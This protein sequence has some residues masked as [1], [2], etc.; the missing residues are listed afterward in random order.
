MW[1]ACAKC[2]LVLG[3]GDGPS[4]LRFTVEYG[5]FHWGYIGM[6][7]KKMETTML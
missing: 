2:G 6:M 1:S 5:V 3:G 7:G 4:T